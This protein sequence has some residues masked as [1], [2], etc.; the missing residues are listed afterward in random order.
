MPLLHMYLCTNYLRT[1]ALKTLSIR[2]YKNN[3]NSS[4]NLFCDEIERKFRGQGWR[5]KRLGGVLQAR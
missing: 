5:W 3:Q 1:Y 2:S 4:Q